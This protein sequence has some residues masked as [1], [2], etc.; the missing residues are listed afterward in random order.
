MAKVKQHSRSHLLTIR[1]DPPLKDEL[2]QALEIERERLGYPVTAKSI[3]VPAIK[4]FV[5][6]NRH[7]LM[8]GA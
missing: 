7:K 1:L 5:R 4:R 3:I 6:R 2:A 8:G